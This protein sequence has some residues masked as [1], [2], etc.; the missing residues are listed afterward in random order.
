MENSIRTELAAAHRAVNAA[1]ARLPRA[2]AERIVIRTDGLDREMDAAIKSGDRE[3]AR[4]AIR[5]FKGHWLHTFE[6]ATP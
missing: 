3:R 1:Y 4:R 6:K 5:A 2:I